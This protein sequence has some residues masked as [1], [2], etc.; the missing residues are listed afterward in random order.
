MSTQSPHPPTP[1]GSRN[2]RRPKKNFTP[3][4]Q[5]VAH[6]TTPP[7]S[8]PRN[9]SPGGITTD[10]SN[11]IQS[12]KKKPPRSTKKPRDVNRAS[13]APNNGHRHTS[14][15]PSVTTPQLKEGAHYAGPTFH[16][17][18]APSALPIPS[19]FSKSVPD[20]D[21]PPTL[22]T[23]SDTADME[24]DLDTTPS[25]PKARRTPMSEDQKPTPLDFLFKAAVQARNS[26][27]A[28]S[29]EVSNR[30]RSPQTDS[31]ALHAHPDAMPGGI[32]PFEMENS[33]RPSSSQI[34]P[35]FAPSYQDRMNALRS[36]SSPSQS[37]SPSEDQ[38]RMKTE[39]L[40]HLLLNPRPQ[41]PPSSVS[42]PY[43]SPGSFRGQQNTPSHVVPHYATPMR[44]TSGPPA[45]FSH[46]FPA[47]PQPPMPH[48]AG[49]PPFP[50]TQSSGLQQVR[51]SNSPLKREVPPPNSYVSGVSSPA[52]YGNPYM[53]HP[54]QHP[55]YAS[56]PARYPS[57]SVEMPTNS[58]S[59]SKSTD[60]KKM[61]DDLRRILKLDG[62]SGL[63]SSGMQSSFA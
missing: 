46:G 59:P 19:F 36:S 52:P 4:A 63:P 38:R 25:K 7:S 8:P 61:E 23:D 12:S 51:N 2:N 6:L 34:G 29:P 33:G 41:K 18:P 26:P 10:S 50:Y 62:P 11:N 49:R 60:T 22:E 47:G 1:K 5:K 43:E 28:G 27:S 48:N 44:T 14:S 53:A 57:A 40:K 58:P 17:S 32:F 30:V 45:T 31:K 56:P 16:A 55:S 35:S 24:P 20:S 39:E 9:M 21:L 3:N 15:Q 13:P 54:P 42:S 37:P